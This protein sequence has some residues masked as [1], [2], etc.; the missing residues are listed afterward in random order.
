MEFREDIL[1]APYESAELPLA[2]DEEGD[3][4]ATLV[5]RLVPGSERAVLYVH[6][7]VDY[8][9][10]THLADHFVERGYSFY[11]LDLRKYGRSLRPHHSPNFV[12]DLAAYDE[13]LDAA[14]R[15]IRE[16]DGHRQLLVNGHSTGGL[17][18][19]LW[20]GRRAGRGVVDGLF[21]NSPFLSSPPPRPSA[22]SAHP[23]WT[24]SAASPPPASSPPRSTRTTCTA[25]TATTA[26]S[27]TSTS[28]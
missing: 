21:L 7:Y 3:V 17:V 12:R 16:E 11:A 28:G 27:G 22:P 8:F 14:V 20:A 13:E 18:T 5:R 25:C 26:A 15:V 1:G 24:P 19:A 10:Q 4:S 9:F 6:G 23:P 2:P